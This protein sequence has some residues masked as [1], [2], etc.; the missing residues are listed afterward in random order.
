MQ[1]LEIPV[2]Q[3]PGD[4]E[5]KQNRDDM[6]ILERYRPVRYRSSESLTLYQTAL[7]IENEESRPQYN[8]VKK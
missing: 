5:A 4:K 8:A 7:G 3:T 2:C 6:I 1:R